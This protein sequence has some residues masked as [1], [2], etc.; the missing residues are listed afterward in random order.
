MKFLPFENITYRTKLTSQ[1][2]LEQ[3]KEVVEPRKTIRWKGI[4][5]DKDH[6]PYEGSIVGNSFTITRIINYRNSFLPTIKGNIES[7]FRGTKVVV[8]MRLNNFVIAFLIFMFIA[9]GAGL[10][11][12]LSVKE[13]TDT[14]DPISLIPLGM[15]LFFYAMVTGGFKYESIKSKKYFAQLFEAKIEE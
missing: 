5:A 7:D 4:F 9:L 2:A 8:Q 3:L 1:E 13:T 15:I 6:K 14:F 12:L 11:A 10:W